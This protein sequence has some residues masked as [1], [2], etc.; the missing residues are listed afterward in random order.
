M[1]RIALLVLFMSCTTLLWA[2]G[3]RLQMRKSAGPFVVTLFTM[4]DT[5]TVGPADL[6]VGVEDA[7]GA[8]LSD[9]DVQL[10]I[11]NGENPSQKLTYATSR[12]SGTSGI[13]KSAMVD[14]AKT[15]QW[16]VVV[17]VSRAGDAGSCETD[18]TVV[19]A[20]QL[21]YELW[22]A[23]ATPFLG[24]LFF[25]LHRYRKSLWKRDR[26]ARIAAA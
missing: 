4:P 6:S 26:V 25:L 10:E 14:F 9:A 19:P 13:L 12:A 1:R 16:H 23:G 15:G 18:L 20:R 2:D 21:R 3:G 24:I 5:P 7:S 8:L 17:H 11:T 22:A